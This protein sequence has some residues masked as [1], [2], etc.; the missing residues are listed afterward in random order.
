MTK[1]VLKIF[2]IVFPVLFFLFLFSF[3]AKAGTIDSIS[4]NLSSR[5]VSGTSSYTILFTP[6]TN[7]STGG[8]VLV[9]FIF[10]MGLSFGLGSATLNASTSAQ[11]SS[12]NTDQS[13]NN[14]LIF[15]T[16][17]LTG[18]TS[19]T[20]KVNNISNP[21]MA[22]KGVLA[23][24]TKNSL[25]VNIDGNIQAT[26][27]SVLSP[28]FEIGTAAFKG[29]VTNPTG[30]P[31][32]N[33]WVNVFSVSG[34]GA[35]PQGSTTNYNGDYLVSTTN[36]S[37]GNYFIEVFP[38]FENGGNMIAPDRAN[39][40]Y[41]GS[42]ITQ[43]LQFIAATKTISGTVKYSDTNTGVSNVT[44]NAFK[45]NGAGY[46][47]ATT[48]S[49]GSYSLSVG[50]GDW[51]VMPQV[52]QGANWSYGKP[53][54][55]A[56]FAADNSEQS[57]TVNF[58]VDRASATITGRLVKPGGSAVSPQSDGIGGVGVFS[59]EGRG[60]GGQLANDGTFSI[61]V[62]AGSY[63]LNVWTQP[64]SE[65][66]SPSMDAIIVKDDETLNLGDI[67]VVSK[68][69]TITGTVKD[70]NGT[71]IANVSLNAFV[72]DGGGF[73]NATTNGL[74]VFE[75]RVSAGTWMVM[76]SFNFDSSYA[77]NTPPQE[78]TI[79]SGGTQTINFTAQSASATINGV[80][81]DSNGSP[82]SAYGYAFVEVEGGGMFGPGGLGGPIERGNFSFKVPAGTY[83]VNAGLAP[84]TNYTPGNATS[85]TVADGETVNIAV[86]LK[87]NDATITGSIID[88]N[89]GAINTSS[90]FVFAVSNSG[91]S[92][93]FQQGTISGNT[94]TINVAAGDWALGYFIDPSAGYMSAPPDSSMRVT[95]AS[96]QSVTKNITLKTANSTIRG[97]VIKPD[98][99]VAVGTFVSIDNR[100]TEGKEFFNGSITDTNGAY[101][102]RTTS[103][104]YKVR[105]NVAPGNN[106]LSPPEQ[107]VTV[108]SSQTQT[109]NFTLRQSDAT[110]TG[111]VTRG[112]NGAGAFVYAYS[113]DGGFAQTTSNAAG[114]YSLSV[115]RGTTWTVGARYES[116]TTPYEAGEQTV[117]VTGSSV[118]VDLTLV[119]TSYSL[120][121]AL[122]T[123][124]DSTKPK[125]IQLTDG[126]EINIPASAL[127]TSGNVT[128]S[129]SP[130]AS[131]PSKKGD[132]PLWYGYEFSATDS[133]GQAITSFNSSITITFPYTD[134]QLTARGIT[135][136]DLIPSYWDDTSGT[137]KKVS[138]VTIDTTAKTV[139]ITVD[140]FTDF[141]LTANFS[142]ST[143]TSSTTSTSSTSTSAGSAGSGSSSPDIYANK[144]AV[145]NKDGSI[146]VVEKDTLPW[147]SFLSYAVNRKKHPLHFGNYWQVS[148]LYDMTFKA[149]ANGA[150][151][152]PKKSSIIAIRY[153]KSELDKLP[154][155]SLRLAQSLDNGKT[156]IV[157]PSSVMDK[158]N[159]TVAAITKIGGSYMLVAGYGT[160]DVYFPK[161]QAAKVVAGAA[162]S[163]VVNQ[164]A[165]P[166]VVPARV[167]VD[168]APIVENIT[169]SEPNKSISIWQKMANFFSGKK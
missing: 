28:S 114:S 15:G 117:S 97:T 89:G 18:G 123:T 92:H 13:G 72:R 112:G 99:T 65:Y 81:Q 165:A 168:E 10:P 158:K 131:L 67:T 104:T 35:Q 155:N 57:E 37:S 21:S 62:P 132:K 64:S 96:G 152:A 129:I 134:A 115:S 90:L 143:T 82:V 2:L 153:E 9:K 109:V 139:T 159:R 11:I 39:V 127:A 40:A 122:T 33:A 80:L 111:T 91:R 34:S 126:T 22:G 59:M 24:A 103:G 14:I 77:I 163:A 113:D 128:L 55:N 36:V 87:T 19:Y 56:K 157:L 120:P 48:D 76:P 47:Q 156:W 95:V 164:V 166:T 140:H 94:Y 119:Q 142:S 66:G 30:D 148:S 44:V 137:W 73:S 138:N 49:N 5:A 61:A 26:T 3:K 161:P 107:T 52:S 141:A 98:G 118:S 63:K 116:G 88:D 23:I 70:G 105:A 102:I 169:K 58:I 8:T 29:R 167:K 101:T 53:P 100:E 93:A 146:I 78:I 106:L 7:V 160:Y 43:N 86:A 6:Q 125:V 46:A 84:G 79:A 147:D 20:I 1:K 108:A 38:P 150:K 124:F 31:V 69:A 25:G 68:D 42:A 85:V 17:G 16:T 145:M 71:G 144:S 60:G 154:E 75:M 149:Y 54:Q 50:G 74:G 83:T 27:P 41:S 12:I 4:V 135:A 130:K 45:M 151:I 133:S 121:Q 110:I 136:D 162:T 32:V 51:G